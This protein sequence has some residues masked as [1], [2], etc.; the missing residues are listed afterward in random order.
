MS[1]L[2]NFPR[3]GGSI[4]SHGHKGFGNPVRYPIAPSSYRKNFAWW[5]IEIPFVLLVSILAGTGVSWLIQMTEIYGMGELSKAFMSI[6]ERQS[7]LMI[8]VP[9]TLTTLYF[10]VRKLNS[11]S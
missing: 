5:L 11:V 6:F 4:M 7:F 10:I 2:S 9:I 3:D 8:V 1:V